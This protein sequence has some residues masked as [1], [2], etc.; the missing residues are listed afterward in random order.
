MRLV[1]ITAE[2]I[3][4][5]EAETINSLF[6]CGMPWMHLRKPF[7]T[8][9]E[10]ADLLGSV[11]PEFYAKIVLHD[12]YALL[13]EFPLAGIH[14][15]ARNNGLAQ[16]AGTSSVS[17]SCHSFDCVKAHAGICD[18]VFL[19][20]VFDSIS[21]SG[22]ASAFS[23]VELAKARADGIVTEK[24]VALGGIG[25]QT[26]P[27]AAAFG[28]GGVAVLGALWGSYLQDRDLASLLKRFRNLSSITEKQ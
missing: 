21:K 8:E 1:T 5:G 27:R 17:C 18:Y 6:D 28:F 19:S 11:R 2:R 12:H 23:E 9:R 3:Y 26:I 20:P 15:N 10:T 22:Y 24:V 14:R 7:A 16:P 4:K 25:P 13:H